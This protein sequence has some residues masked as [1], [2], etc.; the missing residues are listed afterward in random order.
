MCSIVACV[1]QCCRVCDF[2]GYTVLPVF[3]Y[4]EGTEDMEV[5]ACLRL[6]VCQ[7]SVC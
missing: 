5:R 6:K 3:S 7:A 1:S 4:T 2:P